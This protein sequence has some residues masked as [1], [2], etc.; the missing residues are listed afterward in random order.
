M[1]KLMSLF[2]LN[3]IILLFVREWRLYVDLLYLFLKRR[4]DRDKILTIID[5]N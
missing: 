2:S 4:K 1:L 5:I 3:Y